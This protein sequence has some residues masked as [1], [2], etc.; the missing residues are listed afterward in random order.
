M[1]IRIV[2][3]TDKKEI[4]GLNH[5]RSNQCNRIRKTES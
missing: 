4:I 2:N 3:E 1:S 5:H